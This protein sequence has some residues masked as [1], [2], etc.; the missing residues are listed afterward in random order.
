[1]LMR[2]KNRL[3]CLE[4]EPSIDEIPQRSVPDV[5]EKA[6]LILCDQDLRSHSGVRM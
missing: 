5:D 6:V 2:K 3:E 1:M 4:P